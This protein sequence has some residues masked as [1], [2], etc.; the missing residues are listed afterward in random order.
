MGGEWE[1]NGAR[2]VEE[3]QLSGGAGLKKNNF[4]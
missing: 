2:M 1:E 4:F 3:R